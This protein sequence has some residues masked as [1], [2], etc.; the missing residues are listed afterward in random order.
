MILS[1]NVGF[2]AEKQAMSLIDTS[3]SSMGIISVQYASAND[4]KVKVMI[5]KDNSK[6]VY[7]LNNNK[8]EESFPL[9]LQDGTYKISIMENTAGNNYKYVSTNSVDVKLMDKNQTFLQSIQPV[10]WDESMKAIVKAK[11]L[12][13]G[14]KSDEEKINAIYEYIV[15]NVKY[16]YKKIGNLSSDYLPQI[17]ETFTTNKGICYD[18][19]SVFAGMLRSNNIPAKLVKGY[20]KN[21]EGYH[22]WNEVY[23][24]GKWIV[25]DTSYDSQMVEFNKKYSMVKDAKSYDKVNE[26]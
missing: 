5:E 11:E 25:V 6:Y 16:D 3:K 23:L 13:E 20:T 19:A 8:L 21:V 18:F 10:K 17:D 7:N 2:A 24:N 1:T 14:L 15:N 4:K 26:Y 22:A 12:T 9:Q